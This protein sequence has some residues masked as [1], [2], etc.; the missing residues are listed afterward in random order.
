MIFNY[1]KKIKIALISLLII[2]II[3]LVCFLLY[4]RSR[5]KDLRVVNQ[6]QT[7]ATALEQYYDKFNAYPQISEVDVN[8]IKL[9]GNQGI[10][11]SSE[12]AYY[13]SQGEFARSATLLSSGTDYVIKFELKN[14][15]PV[16]QLIDSGGE[17][18][19]T[20][21]ILMTCQQNK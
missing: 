15:W 21:N 16:W 18:R 20:T 4:D 10:N 3:G 13:R 8:S 5:T 6:A 2:V 17:C 14:K 19:L 1:N 7:L 12:F 9:I 11:K